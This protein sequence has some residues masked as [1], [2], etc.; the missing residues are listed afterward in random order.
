MHC[1]TFIQQIANYITLLT[2]TTHTERQSYC[3]TTTLTLSPLSSH[4]MGSPDPE[5]P[6]NIIC[7]SFFPEISKTI[8]RLYG[9]KSKTCKPVFRPY[10]YL[11]KQNKPVFRPYSLRGLTHN[12]HPHSIHDIEAESNKLQSSNVREN[13]VTVATSHFTSDK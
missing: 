7:N 8:F 1:I 6:H 13:N 5:L 2:K 9:N 11:S 4:S 12:I 3:T 10:G